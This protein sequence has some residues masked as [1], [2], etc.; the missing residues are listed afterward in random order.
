MKRGLWSDQNWEWKKAPKPLTQCWLCNA[1]DVTFPKNRQP[2]C[3]STHQPYITST[4]QWY[5]SWTTLQAVLS[6]SEG[7]NSLKEWMVSISDG[8][9]SYHRSQPVALESFSLAQFCT[10]QRIWTI[11]EASSGSCSR[12]IQGLETWSHSLFQ[13]FLL[14]ALR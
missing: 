1:A 14:A 13:D 3:S 6:Q 7:T 10:S 11:P 5:R 12:R 8:D 9:N 2:P 4:E